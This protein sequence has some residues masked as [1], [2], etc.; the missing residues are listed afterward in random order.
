MASHKIRE[1]SDLFR[2]PPKRRRHIDRGQDYACATWEQSDDEEES[3][4]HYDIDADS[5]YHR[6]TIINDSENGLYKEMRPP[7]EQAPREPR[8]F[9]QTMYDHD[10]QWYVKPNDNDNDTPHQ[11]H[12]MTLKDQNDD[13]GRDILACWDY[14]SIQP[15]HDDYT[16]QQTSEVL[17]IRRKE[18]AEK[19]AGWI[20]LHCQ[21]LEWKACYAELVHFS[22]V[23][24]HCWVPSE[25]DDYTLLY[26]WVAK[27]RILKRKSQ[28]SAER[29]CLL[30]QIGFAWGSNT[31]AEARVKKPKRSNKVLAEFCA[32]VSTKRKPLDSV[33]QPLATP[34]CQDNDG[35]SKRRRMITPYCPNI[36]DSPWC[37][38]SSE[39]SNSSEAAVS[40]DVP[41][42][43]YLI[44]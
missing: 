32:T 10:H 42:E 14:T 33:L 38:Y 12:T 34:I 8:N 24:G 25:N 19:K 6:H 13:E 20:E 36:D 23:N 26:N 35:A 21:D 2:L 43:E 31:R 11:K 22:L 28:L 9:W 3:G 5:A 44:I 27:Q 29:E 30:E 16:K 39:N 17:E 37:R 7:W 15:Y 41:Q 40:S 18:Q 1:N 4:Y